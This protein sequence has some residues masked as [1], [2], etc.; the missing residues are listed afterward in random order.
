[1]RKNPTQAT[2]PDNS[3]LA[4]TF[5]QVAY[6]SF[7]PY[8]DHY[9]RHVDYD[10]WTDKIL[11]LYGKHSSLKLNAILELACG[12]A[13][14]SERLVRKGYNVTASDR[15]TEMLKYAS[16]KSNRPVLIQAD[17][18]DDLPPEA[19]D[20]VI[21]VFDS[22]NYL[23]EQADITQLLANV[24][25]TLRNNGLFIFDIST[26][27]NSTENF[28]E[29]IN[30]DETSDYMLIHQADFDSEHRLQKTNLTIFKRSDNHYIRLDEEHQ[31]RVYSV[32]ELLNLIEASP[33]E[34]VGIYSLAYDRNL[35]RTQTRNL[36]HQYSR[37][38]FVLKKDTN[39]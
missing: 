11:E 4:T 22:I 12:T 27:R 10:K 5:E 3:E 17:M 21:L 25:K 38:F 9:M 19:Y 34:C 39:A 13:N 6:D 2:K 20:M 29:Y 33:L 16:L 26:Y 36:D 37:L 18:L 30:I 28:S 35:L 14:I 24:S 7:S 1:M 8:Y 32:Q 23:L 15:S 31:Q